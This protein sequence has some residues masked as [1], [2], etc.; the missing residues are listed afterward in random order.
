MSYNLT[1][2]QPLGALY[3]YDVYYK[4]YNVS[5]YYCS[6]GGQRLE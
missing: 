1:Y 2:Y 3:A 4:S 5:M 6:S